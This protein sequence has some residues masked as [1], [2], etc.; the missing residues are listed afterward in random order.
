MR[1]QRQPGLDEG[2]L[3]PGAL[4]RRVFVAIYPHHLIRRQNIRRQAT[5]VDAARVE[6][7]GLVQDLKASNRIVPEKNCFAAVP[8]AGKC[9]SPRAERLV[10]FRAN[11]KEK[12]VAGSTT[13]AMSF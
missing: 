8:V 6:P 1:L 10:R 11:K 12:V 7:H 9:A 4:H 2:P 3:P 13:G 5:P